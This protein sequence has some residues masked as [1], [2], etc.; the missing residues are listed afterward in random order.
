MRAMI[1]AA[2]RGER[3]RP[4]T[5]T[6][7]KSML[8]VNQKPLIA[9]HVE[10][11]VRSGIVELVINHARF[12]EQIEAYLGDGRAFGARIRYS[13]EN[14]MP[15]LETAGGIINAL[16]L[17]NYAPFMTV[18]AD[19]WTDFPFGELIACPPAN[20]LA[21]IVLV[22]NPPHHPEGDFSLADGLVENSGDQRLTFSG[23]SVFAPEFF[24]YAD[25]KDADG[26]VRGHLA[27]LIRRAIEDH[28][29]TGGHYQGDWYDIGTPERLQALREMV[30]DKSTSR[31]DG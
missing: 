24:K 17:L 12:G 4:L 19:V 28:A 14:G 2:G 29:V 30:I 11:L 3:M 9:Y 27:P 25:Q 15:P 22:D 31:V 5:N 21:H 10:R 26:H 18:N 23:I 8:T 1:L 7:P 6:M 20:R 13:P 16:P